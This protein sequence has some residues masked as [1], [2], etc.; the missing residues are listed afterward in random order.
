[1]KACVL[2]SPAPISTAPL[3]FMEIPPPAPEGD[4]VLVRVRACGVCRT[5]LHVV[6][7]EL[8]PRKSPVIPGHQ[9]VGIVDRVGKQASRFS[10]GSR[11]GIAW[12][13]STDGTC[14]YCRSGSVHLRDE[15]EFT[16]HTVDGG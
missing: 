3:E 4:Q 9:A 2:R 11:V 6:E 8:S 1:M 7:G 5:D 16:G 15:P 13:H 12:L 10:V 14:S